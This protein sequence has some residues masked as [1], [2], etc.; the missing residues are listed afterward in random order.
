FEADATDKIALEQLGIHEMSNVVISV[1]KSMQSSLLIALHLKELGDPRLW[2]KAISD[3]HETVLKK[4]GAEEVI[5]PERFAAQELA[6]KLVI[7][8]VVVY[9]SLSEG[10]MV[11]ELEIKDWDGKSLRQL[12]LPNAYGL[13]VIA[14]K[15]PG[16]RQF[17]F[18]PKADRVLRSGDILLIIGHEAE[19]SKL[20]A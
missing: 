6:R 10:V 7:P 5:F 19:L 13:Q 9:L 14:V 18:V 12:D 2:V 11:R 20:K 3:E 15:P 4:I 1:G 17:D 8:G 16:K